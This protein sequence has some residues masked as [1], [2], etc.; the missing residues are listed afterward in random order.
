MA[1]N[2]ASG[3]I[4][5]AP[6]TDEELSTLIEVAPGDFR[7]AWDSGTATTPRTQIQFGKFKL[8]P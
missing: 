8:K 5:A 3:A 6:M 2:I 7:A 1:A 4:G